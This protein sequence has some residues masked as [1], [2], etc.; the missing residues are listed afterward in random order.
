M[1]ECVEGFILSETLYGETSK[2]INVFTQ[3]YG[4][5]GVIA[6][7]ATR[8][9]SPIRSGCIKYTYG[10]FHIKYQNKKL[11]TLVAVDIID[12]LKNI[13]SD[14]TKISYLTFLSDLTYQVLKENKSKEIYNIFINTV[15]KLNENLDPLILLNIIEVKYLDYLGVGL[16]LNECIMCGNKKEIITIDASYG[17]LICKNCYRNSKIID[18]KSLKLLRMYYLVDIKSISNI[19]I[20]EHIKG[21]INMFIKNYYDSYTGLYIKSKDFLEK[22]INI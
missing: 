19:K 15:L 9:K 10:N 4:L 7:G 3:K 14:L 21:E 12:P 20:D 2:I 5:I 18:V 22:I 11:S 17:G 16:N 6:K 8:V 13:H 1:P